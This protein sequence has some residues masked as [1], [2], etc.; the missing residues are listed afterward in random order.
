MKSI[1]HN[2][3]KPFKY[4][5]MLNILFLTF[6][7]SISNQAAT[8]QDIFSVDFTDTSTYKITC[9]DV[10]A[11]QWSVKNDSC[12]LFTPFFR[13]ETNGC[14]KLHYN[15]TINQSGNMEAEDVLKL[16]YQVD[17][18]LWNTDTILYGN[19]YTAVHLFSDSVSVCFDEV[20][21]FRI[22]MKNNSGSEF[23]SIK[24]GGF[25]LTG[26]FVKYPGDPG[27]GLPVELIS[28]K[29]RC[30][31]TGSVL[32]WATAAE[33]N[34][35]YFTVE[36]T[37]DMLDWRIVTTISGA[38][39]S[40]NEIQ[41]SIID[42]AMVPDKN[43]YYRLKQTDTDGQ[44]KYFDVLAILCSFENDKLDIIGVNASELGV[45]LIIKTD[46]L[47]IVKIYFSDISGKSII[48]KELSPKK[49][50]NIVSLNTPGL[51][52]G[53]YVANVVQNDKSVSKKI[54]LNMN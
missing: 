22:I 11:A 16:Q 38:F 35:E 33:V 31:S 21:R 40:N 27:F 3:N 47:G 23:W 10:N 49:G 46:G 53:I 28:Y 34:N 18:G 19:N 26:S 50:A 51:S 36:K 44:F 17:N 45:N 54:F 39:N 7:F 15:L 29:I 42:S 12:V 20:I 9:G 32:S 24:K 13:K 2:T 8:A 6:L 41:Y 1:I 43:I 25:E 5:G 48:Q 4:S 14:Q 30:T 52:K 37:E